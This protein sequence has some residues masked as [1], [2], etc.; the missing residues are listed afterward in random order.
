MKYLA[1]ACV[2][3][4]LCLSSSVLAQSPPA[5]QSTYR[6]KLGDIMEVTQLRHFKLWYAGRVKNWPL[7]NYELEQIQS[8]F[9]DAMT[10]Y[11]GLPIADM[12]TMAKPAA[13]IG[14]A[15][16]SKDNNNFAKA[17][18]EMTAACNGC[19]QSQG[20]PFIVITVPTSSSFSNQLLHPK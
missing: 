5:G 4:G 20:F 15:I 14:E 9:E 8:S 13:R 16:K 18:G 12:N 19:H 17:F 6:P 3:L 2:T 10:L 11:P 1:V 7:A